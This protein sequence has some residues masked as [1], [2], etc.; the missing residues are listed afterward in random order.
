MAK[1]IPLI[2]G[3]ALLLLAC[4]LSA[5]QPNPTPA[6][7]LP[8]AQI[9][10]EPSP[11]TDLEGEGTVTPVPELPLPTFPQYDLKASLDYENHTIQ[12]QE[13][14]LYPNH[15]EEAI[16]ELVLIA[17]MQGTPNALKVQEIR[18]GNEP[19]TNYEMNY[20]RLTI[21]LA[22]PLEPETSLQL[23]FAYT[24]TLPNHKSPL[25]YTDLQANFHNWYFFFPPYQEEKGWK[26][27]KRSATVPAWLL[28]ILL[29]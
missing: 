23:S 16:R 19:V 28:A 13:T 14:I 1:R 29:L 11:T 25:G 24:L 2:L 27:E 18:L 26:A 21:P 8:T 3:L 10:E 6:I 22:R 4:D 15:S 5:P 9:N 12:V 20:A 7:L 17:E